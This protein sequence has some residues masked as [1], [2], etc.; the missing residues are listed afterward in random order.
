MPFAIDATPLHPS[1]RL[2]LAALEWLEPRISPASI[3]DMGCGNGILSLA[4][5]HCWDSRI[6]ACDI[7]PEAIRDTN[8]NIRQ[9]AP[10]AAIT[11]LR[12]DGFKH[13]DI[14]R[15]APYSLIIGNLIAQWQVQMARDMASMLSPGG[16]VLL[17]GMLVWQEA[18][19]IEALATTNINIIHIV[20]ED[21]WVCLIGNRPL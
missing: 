3:L 17:S 11:T 19:V 8:E 20:R 1:T 10:G 21:S 15:R 13:P 14:A 16:Y 5:A 9:H 2:A 18:G 7:A 6:L 12:S 4:S